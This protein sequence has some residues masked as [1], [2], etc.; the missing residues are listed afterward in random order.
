MFNGAPTKKS[1]IIVYDEKT[2][3]YATF[4]QQLISQTDDAEENIVGIKDGS[5]DASLWSVKEYESSLAKLT[6][7][8]HIVF[9]GSNKVAKAQGKN[10]NF[11]YSKHGMNFGWLGKRAVLYVDKK[12]LKKKEYDDFF[13]YSKAFQNNLKKAKTNFINTLP[14]AVKWVGVFL[15]YV[16]P[17]AIYGLISGGK[18]HKQIMDQQFRCLTLVFYTDGLQKFL[19]G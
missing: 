18:A 13:E 11:S 1:L 7:N 19:E 17:A 5:V 8:T 9:L 10:I 16:Y 3:E 4:L 6:S 14:E 15:P 12:V 2:K